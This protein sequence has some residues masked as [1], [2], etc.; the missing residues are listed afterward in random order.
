MYCVLMI[1]NF[2]GNIP[3]LGWCVTAPLALTCGVIFWNFLSFLILVAQR[4]MTGTPFS[5]RRQKRLFSVFAGGTT[6]AQL[7]I[8][9][10][11]G[12]VY[13]LGSSLPE[14]C[15]PFFYFLTLALILIAVVYFFTLLVSFLAARVKV[16]NG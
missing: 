12:K 7:L 5:G 9:L 2:L 10:C 14:S 16:R 6:V 11:V 1:R 4:V 13:M 3:I 15:F 8:Y